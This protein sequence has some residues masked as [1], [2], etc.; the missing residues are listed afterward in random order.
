ML[1]RELGR[2]EGTAFH[3]LLAAHVG[4]GYLEV[5]RFKVK[6]EQITVGFRARKGIASAQRA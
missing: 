4:L 6:K 5:S 1:L 2:L 3:K